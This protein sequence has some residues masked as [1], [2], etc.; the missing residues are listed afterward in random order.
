MKEQKNFKL[1]AT[2]LN[3]L[4]WFNEGDGEQ[5]NVILICVDIREKF[6]H[7]VHSSCPPF[8]TDFRAIR[9]L[10]KKGLVE[11]NHVNDFSIAW[12]VVTISQKGQKFLEAYHD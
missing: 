5:T 7:T 3:Y 1:T 6:G 12:Q 2:Q 4:Q 9:K 8:K 11:A 10:Y